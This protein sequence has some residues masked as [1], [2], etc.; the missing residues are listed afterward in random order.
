[1]GFKLRTFL[2]SSAFLIAGSLSALPISL[3]DDWFLQSGW[4]MSDALEEKPGFPL[5]KLKEQIANLQLSPDKLHEITLRKTVKVTQEDFDDAIKDSF[6][7]HIPFISNVYRIYWNG[8]LLQFGGKIENGEILESGYRRHI[9]IK[10]QRDELLLGDNSLII[11]L[12]SSPGEEMNIYPEMNN[13]AFSVDTFSHLDQINKEYFTYM[14]IFL[15]LFVGLYHGL[16][17]LKRPQEKYNGFYALFSIFLSVYLFFRSQA[18]YI[19][20]ADPYLITRMEYFVIFLTPVNLLLFMDNFFRGDIGRGSRSY[21]IFVAFLAVAQLFASRS[22]SMVFLTV[23]QVSVLFTIGYGF[24]VMARAIRSKNPDANRMILGFVL[25]AITGIWDVLGAM[26]LASIQNFNLLRFG[27]LFFVLGIAVILANRFLSVHN[28][29][30]NLNANLEKKVEERTNELQK[31]LERVQELKVQQ[32]GDYFLTSLLLDPLGKL[33]ENSEQVHWESYTK[34]KKEFEFRSRSKDIGGDI[35]ITDR[36]QLNGLNYS[37]FVNGDA[38][39]KSMQGAGGALVLGVVFQSVIKRTQL[40]SESRKRTPE[41]W[42]KECFIEL[43]SIFE[44]FQGSML[45]SVVMGLIEEETGVLYYINA[46]HPWTVMYRDGVANF[47][48][49]QLDLRKIGTTGLEG[50]VKIRIYQ[51]EK[52]DVLIM[53]SDGRD[54]LIVGENEDGSR[55]INEDENQFLKRVEESGGDLKKLVESLIRFGSLSDDLSLLRLEWTGDRSPVDRKDS[56]D[57]KEGKELFLQKRYEEA[58]PKLEFVFKQFPLDNEILLLLSYCY[59]KVKQIHKAI[60]FGEKLRLRE[61]QNLSN[62]VHLGNCFRLIGAK[63]K[64]RKLCE[65]ALL[66]SPEEPQVLKLQSQLES[67]A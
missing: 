9:I 23:W 14:L 58:L 24:Y 17:Y 67:V 20:P 61:P 38:M 43:Q 55:I 10:L 26:G 62:L 59:K 64:A 27:F 45:V 44:S 18:V 57:W 47:I 34:Q 21:G 6:A 31:T 29:V 3:L 63:E 51:L 36:I 46:E 60:D 48:E 41:R 49:N 4:I 65:R 40:K 11:Q 16:F 42:V 8:K 28:E 54:D 5:N 19:I 2:V 50:E 1:L 33:Q 25:L 37:V 32:D 39:G 66:I 30:E 7:L 52:G 15:Y 35:I 53:G 13:A 12:A 22:L 56:V